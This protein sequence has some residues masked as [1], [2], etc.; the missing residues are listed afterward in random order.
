MKNPKILRQIHRRQ[1]I[2]LESTFWSR[3]EVIATAA[4]KSAGFHIDENGYFELQDY[5]VTIAS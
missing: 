2:D 5:K 3:D 1:D 4:T